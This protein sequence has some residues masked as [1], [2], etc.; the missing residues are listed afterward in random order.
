M[1]L[2]TVPDGFL[3]F[4]PGQDSG[5]SHFS[6]CILVLAGWK[7]RFV[8]PASVFWHLLLTSLSPELG[9]VTPA[10][11]GFFESFFC[12]TL[13]STCNSPSCVSPTNSPGAWIASQPTYKIIHSSACMFQFS[14]YFELSLLLPRWH[15]VLT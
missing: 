6:L 4:R 1:K 8:R 7:A 9:L 10:F 11:L 15:L 13:P 14:L 12:I 3:S 5:I 2:K